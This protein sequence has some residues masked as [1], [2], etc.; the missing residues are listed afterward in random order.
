MRTTYA[1]CA[2]LLLT[3]TFALPASAAAAEAVFRI[4]DRLAPDEI[5][6]VTTVYVDDQLVR[7]FRLD[8][9]AHDIT[10]DVTVPDGAGEHHYALC[11]QLLLRRQDGSTRKQTFAVGG[12]LSDV[13]GREF[14]A[15]ASDDF[16]RFYLVETTAGRPPSVILPEETHACVPAVS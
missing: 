11:G 6:E 10:V 7:S 9:D 3:A 4:R 5:A 1:A 14:E 8:G 16:T 15:F 2:A 12:M 13:G